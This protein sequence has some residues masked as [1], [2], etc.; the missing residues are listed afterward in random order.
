MKPAPLILLLSIN[1]PAA[2]QTVIPAARD[3]HMLV[4][5]RVFLDGHGPFKMMIDTGNESNLIR[6]EVARRIGARPA[7]AVEQVTLAGTRLLPAVIISELKVDSVVD[8]GVEA[9][10]GDVRQERVDGVLGQSWLVRHDYLLEYAHRRL[11]LDGAPPATGTR[12]ALHYSDRRP[13][14][15]AEI[16][17]RRTELVLD[18]GTPVVVLFERPRRGT[19]V[20]VATNGGSTFGEPTTVAIALGVDRPR[21]MPAIRVDSCGTCPG[22][23]PLSAFSGVYVS[24]REHFAVVVP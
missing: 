21:R 18:S 14:V 13:A 11:V 24:N 3:G 12:V 6:P 15:S 17:R 19:T 1:I 10:I 20:S 7:Y 4:L 16:D 8:R 9:L 2:A 5:G 23:L 22:L